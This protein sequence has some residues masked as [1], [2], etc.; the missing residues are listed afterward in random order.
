MRNKL[1]QSNEERLTSAIEENT[2]VMRSLLKE[3][4]KERS[5][6]KSVEMAGFTAFLRKMEEVKS[7]VL[8]T[9]IILKRKDKKLP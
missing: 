2:S 6:D 1:H 5:E 4:S 8:A 7:A 3:L 9:N